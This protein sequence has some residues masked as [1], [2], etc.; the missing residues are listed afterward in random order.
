V[1]RITLG[2]CTVASVATSA[3]A[4][5]NTTGPAGV[6]HAHTLTIAHVPRAYRLH[7]P[8]HFDARRTY[9][10][11][12]VLHGHGES[13]ERFEAAT[14]MSEKA[15]AEGFLV[16]YPQAMGD[17]SEWHSAVDGSN[18]NADVAFINQLI[19][20]I[21]REYHVDRRRV[22]V[23]GHSNG[24]FMAYRLASQLSER[25]AA[26]GVT[27][28]SIGYVD[29]RRDTVRISAPNTPVAVIHFHGMA[30]PSV[31]YHGGEE[32]DGPSNIVSAPN[33]IHFWIAADHCP[34]IP[35]RTVSANKNVITDRYGPCA[36]GTDVVFYTIIDGEHRW[37]G[38][39]VPW[40]TFPDREITDVNATD[41]M[42]AFF[43]AHPKVR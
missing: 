21:E 36:R 6:T 39:D 35:T 27:A 24:G 14:G 26:V 17:P 29:D 31:P 15:D 34:A 18:D 25:I 11:V 2:G 40:W 5:Q 23:A 32:D 7:V 22:Y 12:I 38:D 9:P 42:W 43:H 37:P 19:S 13:A 28:G 16:A 10:L 41:R 4:R 1:R 33:T 8:L 20:T 3:C 30:D